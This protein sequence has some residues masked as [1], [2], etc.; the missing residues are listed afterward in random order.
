MAIAMV[1]GTGLGFMMGL[2]ETIWWR[3]FLAFGAAA[4]MAHSVMFAFSRGGMLGLII[5]GM[6]SFLIIPKRPK[7]YFMFA[8]AV[9]LALRLAGPAVVERFAMT[10]ADER[11]RD[12]SAESRLIMWGNCLELMARHP[13]FGVGPDHFPLVVDQ[14]GVYHGKEAHT[15][16]LQT[17]AELGLPGLGFLVAYYGLCCLRLWQCRH[18]LAAVH[19][20]LADAARMVIASIAGF[21]VSAQFVSLEGLELPYYV[22]MIG[23]G[24]LKVAGQ[25]QSAVAA[26]ADRVDPRETRT[27]AWAGVS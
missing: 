11:E 26:P 5:T 2:G 25:R 1:A 21:A 23:A 18:R 8:V 22:T 6:V 12:G 16:W 10:F 13:V 3:K 7:H 17:G 4:L 20:W 15:L 27:I 9:A 24:A 19:P 14:F